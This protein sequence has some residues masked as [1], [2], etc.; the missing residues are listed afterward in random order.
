MS[1]FLTKYFKKQL[2]KYLQKDRSLVANLKDALEAFNKNFAISI[3]K[4]VYKIRIRAQNKGKSGGYRVY[5]LLLEVKGFIVPLCIYSK[6]D[7]ENLTSS[8]LKDHL[9]GVLSEL[10]MD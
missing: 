8:E 7:K 5:L 2:K 9:E 3:G 10:S 6:S 1:F 4:G